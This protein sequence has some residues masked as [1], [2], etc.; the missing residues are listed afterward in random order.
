MEDLREEIL[1][2]LGKEYADT[3]TAL[4]Y[5]NAYE[6]LVATIL[7]AQCTD[8]RVNIVTRA[9]FIRFP[10]AIALSGGELHEVEELIKTCGLY[11]SKAKNLLACAKRL[12]DA[13]GGEVP[14]TMDELVS[15]AGVGRKTASVVL[16]YAFG[17][18]AMAVDT[19][20]GR[21]ANRLGLAN[22]QNPVKIEQQ[23]CA[24][25]PMERWADAHHWL[26]WHG[27]KVCHAQRPDCPGCVVRELCP[28]AVLEENK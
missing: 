12:T 24:L 15:L 28:S 4:H 7:A 26:I 5:K 6:L 20:V 22:S 21:V 16:A 11:K 10:D 27:R 9:L 13:F 23:L 25:I 8:K 2:R 3:Q 14:H 17:I 1:G 19:H 18:P